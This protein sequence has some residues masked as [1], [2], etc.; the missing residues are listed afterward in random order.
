M[1]FGEEVEG[2]QG[3][4]SSELALGPRAARPEELR[5]PS[6]IYILVR[7]LLTKTATNCFIPASLA[8]LAG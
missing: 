7:L 1:S 5:H 4:N 2:N 3:K 6:E 8:S